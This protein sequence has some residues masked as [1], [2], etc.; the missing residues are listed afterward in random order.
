MTNSVFG[1]RFRKNLNAN[2]KRI[3]FP[4]VSPKL[5]TASYAWRDVY[6]RSY[7]NSLSFQLLVSLKEAFYL[8]TLC[9]V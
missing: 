6:A 3:F 9:D 4:E 7:Y 5:A 2:Y 8:M 1:Y